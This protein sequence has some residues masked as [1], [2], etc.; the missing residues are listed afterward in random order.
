MITDV[1]TSDEVAAIRR[2][3]GLIIRVDHPGLPDDGQEG[4][5]PPHYIIGG[6][7]SGEE[8]R[9]A[10]LRMVRASALTLPYLSCCT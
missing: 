8:L 9:K 3:A 6:G 1:R 2:K 7:L 5:K 4:M 10:L